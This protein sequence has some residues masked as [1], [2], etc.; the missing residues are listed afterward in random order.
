MSARSRLRNSGSSPVADIVHDF[1][2]I[3]GNAIAP[4]ESG[5]LEEVAFQ[6]FL[7]WSEARALVQLLD[8]G[9]PR[10]RPDLL[11]AGPQ[12]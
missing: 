10:S 12:W 6:H 5:S 8:N 2:S 9:L 7:E 1:P 4:Q 11:P 3:V